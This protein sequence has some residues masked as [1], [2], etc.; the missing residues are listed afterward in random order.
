MISSHR[1][2]ICISLTVTQEVNSSIRL[3]GFS[4]TILWFSVYSDISC[5]NQ[6]W[7]Y[8]CLLHLLSV[9]RAIT[10]PWYI[11]LVHCIVPPDPIHFTEDP[12]S[13]SE[14]SV[15]FIGQHWFSH[16]SFWSPNGSSSYALPTSMQSHKY[17]VRS[18]SLN[19][20]FCYQV[21]HIFPFYPNVFSDA[22]FSCRRRSLYWAP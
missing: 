13:E 7:L 8:L 2:A 6:C 22:V 1:A 14:L 9:Q 20:I 4:P 15:K 12:P 19:R 10:L 11:D 16:Y 3:W 21:L 17:N 18:L 5:D